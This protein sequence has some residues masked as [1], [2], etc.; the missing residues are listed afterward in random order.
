MKKIIGVILRPSVSDDGHPTQILY[1]NIEKAVIKANGLVVGIPIYENLNNTYMLIN[2]CD[3]II[4]QGGDDVTST[5]IEI[6]KYL[7]D[8]NIPTLG[9]CLG[10]QTMG[11]LDGKLV[12]LPDLSHYNNK[13][14]YVHDI[15]IDPN[16]LL[17]E[18]IG[19]LGIK[20]NSRHK[21][22]LVDTSLSISAVSLNG[23][24]EAI[25]DYNKTFFIGVQWHPESMIDYDKYANK[26][27][28]ALIKYSGGKLNDDN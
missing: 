14:D 22:H 23:T 4:L 8:N 10:M 18:I 1:D 13:A 26:L 3:G 12:D 28:E 19:D 17:Y 5:D 15:K 16:S 27:F 6:A 24:I 20:V 11:L 2:K 21:S 25:E 9:I 7:Y